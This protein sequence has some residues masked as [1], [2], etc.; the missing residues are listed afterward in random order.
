[1]VRLEVIEM[2][3]PKADALSMLKAYAAVSDEGQEY[4]L[5]MALRRA[6]GM[7]QSFADVALL[8]G[9]FCVKADDHGGEVR[10]YMGGNVTG[11]VN[12]EGAAVQYTQRGYNVQV[13]ATGYVEV[14]FSTSVNAADY[15]RLL[16]VV[17]KYATAVYDGKDTRELNQILKECL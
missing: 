9:K 13:G 15:D 12:A 6:F 11:V 4:L 2:E 17:L 3:A 7:V 14:S 10:V 8:A 1:M 16:P 5:S